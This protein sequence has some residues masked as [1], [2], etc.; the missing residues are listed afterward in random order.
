MG[1]EFSITLG[2]TLVLPPYSHTLVGHS[3]T[4]YGNNWSCEPCLNLYSFSRL[5]FLQLSYFGTLLLK[6]N[7]LWLHL[8]FSYRLSALLSKVQGWC[9]CP[10]LAAETCLFSQMH[11]F[12]WGIKYANVSQVIGFKAFV[13]SQRLVHSFLCCS[14]KAFSECLSTECVNQYKASTSYP[15]PW[16][17]PLGNPTGCLNFW[18]LVC[19]NSHIPCWK[20]KRHVIPLE[21]LYNSGSNS[22]PHPRKIQIPHPWEGCSQVPVGSWGGGMLNHWIDW[23]NKIKK[24]IKF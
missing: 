24:K 16:V 8:L 22:L 21:G 5:W 14:R 9:F 3:F 12:L 2:S 15:P 11:S 13:A 10:W 18:R 17:T 6:K 23:H 4:A 19:S 20:K 1:W 7:C